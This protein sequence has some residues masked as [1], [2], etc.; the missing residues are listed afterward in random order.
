VVVVV[1]QMLRPRPVTVLTVFPP[2]S[3][4]APLTTQAVVV[5]VTT[6]RRLVGLAVA[7]GSPLQA[8]PMQERQ[9]PVV[10]AQAAGARTALLV[11]PALLSSDG[12]HRVAGHPTPL[13]ARSPVQVPRLQVVLSTTHRTQALE[14]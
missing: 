10:V 1:V 11:V 9:I 14:R 13:P 8:H 12:F 7:V 3:R 5:L 4:E 6:P 2:A